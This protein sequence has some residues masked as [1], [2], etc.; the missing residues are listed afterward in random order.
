[1]LYV[2][3]PH[4]AICQRV[5]SVDRRNRAELSRNHG[6]MARPEHY[7]VPVC[8]RLGQV[9]PPTLLSAQR[10]AQDAKNTSRN[11]I[12]SLLCC[13]HKPSK[14]RYGFQVYMLHR[15]NIQESSVYNSPLNRDPILPTVGL[16]SSRC[17][18]NPFRLL[19]MN[20]SVQKRGSD[21]TDAEIAATAAAFSEKFGGG[22]ADPVA[23]GKTSDFR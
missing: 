8:L 14:E 19:A 10:H 22:G 12:V 21:A 2:L 16:Q 23:G 15:S 6:I 5:L 17:P 18:S 11:T 7:D 20:W 9:S 4:A 3:E 1:M 13:G